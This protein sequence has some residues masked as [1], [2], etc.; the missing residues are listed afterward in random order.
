MFNTLVCT[1]RSRPLIT[2]DALAAKLCRS[3]EKCD[4]S[5][6]KVAALAALVQIGVT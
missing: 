3:A 1:S 2:I 6:F 4:D 5:C